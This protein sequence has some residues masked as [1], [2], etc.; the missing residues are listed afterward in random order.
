MYVTVG[1]LEVHN[2]VVVLEEVDFVDG[3]ER[4]HAQ[5]LNDRLDL[6]VVVDLHLA[7]PIPGSSKR[8]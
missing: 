1:T 4:L 5:L 2:C 7:E 3:L 8:P 6:L